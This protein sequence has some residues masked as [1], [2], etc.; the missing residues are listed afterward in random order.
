MTRGS[1]RDEIVTATLQAIA[2]QTRDLVDAMADD[3]IAPSIIRVD[4]GMV[5][6][7]WFLQFLADILGI[8]VERPAN[9]ESTVLGAAYLA[10]LKSGVIAS[11]EQISGLWQR[12]ELYEPDMTSE[13][14]EQLLAG[15]AAAV[16]RV[17]AGD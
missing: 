13:R 4:G 5:A 16:A 3:G 7:S 15:W 17:R 11:I 1:G 2:F 12:D 10:G 9:V 14:R 6:N 8:A